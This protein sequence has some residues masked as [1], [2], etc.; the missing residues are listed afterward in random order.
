[1]KITYKY[2]ILTVLA[3]F[4][5]IVSCNTEKEP[6]PVMFE[7]NPEVEGGFFLTSTSARLPVI[8]NSNFEWS[9]EVDEDWCKVYPGKGKDDGRFYISADN[10]NVAYPRT[11]NLTVRNGA[12]EEIYTTLLTQKGIPAVLDIVGSKTLSSSSNGGVFNIS[13]ISNII[14]TASV[15]EPVNWITLGESTGSTQAISIAENTGEEKRYATIRFTG[16]GVENVYVDVNVVQLPVYSINNATLISVSDAIAN[17][18]GLIEDNLKITGYVTNDVTTKNLPDNYMYIQDQSGKGLLVEFAHSTDNIYTLNDKLTIWLTGCQMQTSQTGTKSLSSVGSTNIV[19]LTKDNINESATPAEVYDLSTIS[20][21]NN[22]LVT[23]KNVYFAAP[24]GTLFNSTGVRTGTYPCSNFYRTTIIDSYGNTAIIN[25]LYTFTEKWAGAISSDRYDITGI[26][27]P[28]TG[29]MEHE[30]FI[31]TIHVRKFS[32]LKKY[33]S[34]SVYVPIV[35]W[36]TTSAVSASTTWTPATGSGTFNFDPD[37]APRNSKASYAD[38]TLRYAYAMVNPSLGY[39]D[40]NSWQGYSQYGWWDAST[41]GQY[42][43]FSTSTKNATGDI[44]LTLMLG[45][46]GSAPAFWDVYWSSDGTT[47]NHSGAYELWNGYSNSGSPSDFSHLYT[48]QE[49]AYKLNGAQGKDNITVRLKVRNEQSIKTNRA[50]ISISSPSMV[51]Y[52]G[53]LEKKN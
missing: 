3:C 53:V 9:V 28:E 20:Q 5:A 22:T 29:E 38:V 23:L 48:T 50:A 49:F 8:I 11:C 35:Q 24:L 2:L 27:Y 15:I 17:C 21:Y 14:W 47:W 51:F 40:A 19:K 31:N 13:L 44:F 33:T 32:D 41:G 1:M 42:W 26:M 7:I 37:K 6:V 46:F 12:G 16:V 4:L 52:I 34:G 45:S 30:T 39:S 43:E 36:Y 10:L 25:T 18:S